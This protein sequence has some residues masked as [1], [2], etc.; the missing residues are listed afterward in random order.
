MIQIV[1][2]N[3]PFFGIIAFTRMFTTPLILPIYNYSHFCCQSAFTFL[4]RLKGVRGIS[5]VHY[6][7]IIHYNMIWKINSVRYS[8]RKVSEYVT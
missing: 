7:A 6:F 5:E 4:R 1:I 8:K 3:I 2:V